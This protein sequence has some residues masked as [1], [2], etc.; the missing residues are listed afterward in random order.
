MFESKTL[1]RHI[2]RGLIGLAAM[3]G[4]VVLARRADGLSMIGAAIL[5]IVAL[6]AWRGC[7]IC[8]LTGLFTTPR[9]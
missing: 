2:L 6:V 8:W 1:L 4:A 7:P 9:R 5:V 3:V